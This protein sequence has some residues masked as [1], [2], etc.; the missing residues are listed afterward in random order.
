MKRF[1]IVIIGG[2]P[3]GSTVGTLLKKYF[4]FSNIALLEAAIFPRHH[5]GESLLAGGTPV[6]KEMAVYDKIDAAD[7]PE[8]LGAS[9][10]W[11]A[12]GER[13]GFEFEEI[14]GQL[15]RDGVRLPKEYFKGWQVRR[16][17]YDKI[18]LDHAAEFGVEV[19]HGA[20]VTQV[21]VEDEAP[22]GVTFVMDGREHEF[23]AD[24]VVDC[25][26]QKG[27]LAGKFGLREY[28]PKLNNI[29]IYGYW[30]GA[31]WKFEYA[32]H[33]GV[34]RI[35]I[36]ST[37]RGW[38]WYIPVTRDTISVGFVTHLSFVKEI[39]DIKSLYFDELRRSAEVAELLAPATLTRIAPDQRA[40]LLV[41]RDWSYTCKKM[42][43]KGWMLVGDAAGFVDPILSSG[44][45][46]AHQNGQKAAYTLNTIFSEANPTRSQAVLQFYETAYGEMLSAYRQMAAYWYSNNFSRD[47][48]WWEAW[49]QIFSANSENA[50]NDRD[51]FMR[52]ASG[53]AN[54]T[55]SLGLFGSYTLSEARHL[56]RHLFAP[57][58]EAP[59]CY[60]Q[61]IR[62]RLGKASLQ[63]GF[64]FH[65]GKVHDTERVTNPST[66][67]YLDLFPGESRLVRR[68]MAGCTMAELT[69]EPAKSAR[70]PELL[71]TQLKQM[72]LIEELSDRIA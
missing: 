13:W 69:R 38:I 10:V 70:T 63:Q 58:G 37:P 20:R 25:S 48:W 12:N 26:G 28:D 2:G 4:P 23:E 41:E 47:G 33:P 16:A 46:L 66:N 39:G 7:F 49:R 1:D 34:T 51:S 52:L 62:I 60:D 8:K 55:E 71:V 59:Q 65:G 50:L 32:G 35:L 40:D 27:V 54:R 61:S 14:D 44:V 53:Y 22:R 36:A 30:K 57:G 72:G 19:F 24:F 6:L 29:A 43:G 56:A 17:E 9:Y 67:G 45:L 15:Q 31:K 11:G 18:L 5:V 21:R 64:L 3:A 68:L 42:S